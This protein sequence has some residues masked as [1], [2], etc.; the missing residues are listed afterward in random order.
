MYLQIHIVFYLY[1]SSNMYMYL[2]INLFIFIQSSQNKCLFH[3]KQTKWGE[4]TVREELE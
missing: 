1:V 4:G 2:Q 3:W